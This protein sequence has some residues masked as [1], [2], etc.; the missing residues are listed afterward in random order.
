[1]NTT[2]AVEQLNTSAVDYTYRMPVELFG[3]FNKGTGKR[4]AHKIAA[5]GQIKVISD[6]YTFSVR[7]GGMRSF[8]T[9]TLELFKRDLNVS[10]STVRRALKIGAADGYIT[11]EEGRKDAYQ[12][13]TENNYTSGGHYK[14]EAWMTRPII[15]E[16]N[17]LTLTNAEQSVAA[18]FNSECN[19]APQEYSANDIA[20]TLDMSVPTVQKAID[21]L[22]DEK[23]RL[24]YRLSVGKNQ[25]RKSKYIINRTLF[26]ALNREEAKKQKA[27]EKALAKKN[28]GGKQSE[29]QTQPQTSLD[30]E[31]AVQTEYRE[32]VNRRAEALKKTLARALTDM[33]FRTSEEALKQ[34]LPRLEFARLRKMPNLSKLQQEM[35]DYTKRRKAALKRLK[36]DEAELSESFYVLCPKCR[37]TL[38][39]PN[40]AV[41]NCFARGAPPPDGEL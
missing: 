13:D 21:K 35:D 34:L 7:R 36:I 1:M 39:F 8:C 23:F 3:T 26:R 10:E 28:V 30:F 29:G 16:D 20:E 12:F 9:R 18:F 17:I 32:R 5:Y 22:T 27:I 24:V 19:R 37:D 38:I 40:G 31:E 2:A 41:C 4:T 25:Y 15:I 33:E 6:I 14:L 11:C